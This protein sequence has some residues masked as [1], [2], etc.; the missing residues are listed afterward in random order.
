MLKQYIGPF[1]EVEVIAF[2]KSYGNVKPGESVAIPDDVASQ[3][4][5][6]E[7]IWQ[8]ATAESEPPKVLSKIAVKRIEA[9]NG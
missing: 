2:G 6:S 7:E 8:D 9:D 4:A 1:D 3:L 5:W